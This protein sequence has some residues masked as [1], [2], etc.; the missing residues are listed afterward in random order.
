MFDRVGNYIDA[1]S[2]LH[3][4]PGAEMSLLY[5][6]E[7]RRQDETGFKIVPLYSLRM[8]VTKWRMID[9]SCDEV[10]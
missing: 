2:F 7:A 5:V 1:G 6:G 8:S 3:R 10:G 9:T 4:S